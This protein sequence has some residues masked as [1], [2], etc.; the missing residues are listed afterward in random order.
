MSTSLADHL[1]LLLASRRTLALSEFKIVGRAG[2]GPTKTSASAPG[3]RECTRS[4]VAP[5]CSCPNLRCLWKMEVLLE[6][7]SLCT[8]S[9]YLARTVLE[10]V[11]L[12]NSRTSSTSCRMRWYPV[13]LL[14]GFLFP[15]SK[16]LLVR[17]HSM[18]PSSLATYAPYGSFSKIF[19]VS[20]AT[21]RLAKS[22]SV[23]NLAPSIP[24]KLQQEKM[25]AEMV[26]RVS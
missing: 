22:F 9:A 20:T 16:S 23:S 19:K 11:P 10:E 3:A 17:Y 8:N 2:F 7:L 4:W 21:C 13:D 25:K 14:A 26:S 12:S 5:W 15:Y 6:F 1:G 24:P 18:K